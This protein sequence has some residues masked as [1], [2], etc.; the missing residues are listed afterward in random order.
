MKICCFI[1]LFIISTH[2]AAQ[3]SGV[4]KGKVTFSNTPNVLPRCAVS[5]LNAKDSILKKTGWADGFGLFELRVNIA[6]NYI[7]FISSEGY[8]DKYINFRVDSN[9]TVTD[10]GITI[11]DKTPK[12]LDEVVVKGKT[13][14]MKLVGDTIEYKASAFLVQKNATVE[15]LLRQFPGLKVDRNGN[16]TSQGQSIKKVLVDGEEFFSDDPTFVT[17][18]LRAEMVEKVQLY[19]KNSES[20]ALMGTNLDGKVKTIDVKLRSDKR[21]G[22]F[23]KFVGGVANNDHYQIQGMVNKFSTK[24]KMASYGTFS[25]TQTIGLGQDDNSMINSSISTNLED[26]DFYTGKYNGSGLPSVKSGGAHYDQK[27]SDNQSLN[28]NYKI[29]SILVTG[30]TQSTIQQTQT[31][32]TLNFQNDERFR[33]NAFRQK[34]DLSYQVSLDP[35]FFFKVYI[36]GQIRDFQRINELATTTTINN[37]ALLNEAVSNYSN[38][39]KQTAAGL[40]TLLSKRFKKIGR[41]FLWRSS[42]SQN[43]LKTTG[44]LQSNVRSPDSIGNIN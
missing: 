38:Q 17:K 15:D 30:S 19:D 16:I 14:G 34:F 42:F 5:I 40:S 29:G 33:D 7:L 11:M 27:I 41:S 37:N 6:G 9:V 10:V 25:N 28:T 21:N 44:E 20:D 12:L 1:L 43:N 24:R 31:D 26:L 23:G 32:G 2:V 36:D 8:M 22:D 3:K 4:V 35:T 13:F 18:N 39:G